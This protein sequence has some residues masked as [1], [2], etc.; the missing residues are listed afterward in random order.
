MRKEIR[1]MLDKVNNN[2]PQPITKEDPPKERYHTREG[3]ERI[4][5][6]RRNCF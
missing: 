1:E 5:A 6:F 4:I 2:A 3:L